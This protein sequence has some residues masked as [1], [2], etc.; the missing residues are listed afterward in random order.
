MLKVTNRLRKLGIKFELLDADRL[1]SEAKRYPEIIA[2]YLGPNWVPVLC[3][4]EMAASSRAGFGASEPSLRTVTG[5]FTEWSAFKNQDLDAIREEFRCGQTV[6]AR[7]RL[8]AFRQSSLWK[9][10][11]EEVKARALRLLASITLDLGGGVADARQLAEEARRLDA[12]ERVQILDALLAYHEGTAA[13][14]LA[15]LGQPRTVDAWNVQLALWLANGEKNRVTDGVATPSFP[16]NAETHRLYAMALLFSQRVEE[17]EAVIAESLAAQ[18]E[19]SAMRQS[20]ATIDYVA[21]INPHFH[22]WMHL[23][24]PVPS[25]RTLVKS[26][27][28]SRSKLVRSAAA[29]K[30]LL[31][32][33]PPDASRRA[34]LETW[35]LA[36]LANHPDT[37][38]EAERW[39][40]ELLNANAAHFRVVIWALE[41]GFK[42]DRPRVRAALGEL[43]K[44]PD[45][46]L[47]AVIALVHLISMDGDLA[48]ARAL[49]EAMRDRFVG[50]R[51]E[52]VWRFLMM[53]VLARLGDDPAADALLTEETD[54]D[55]GRK[56]RALVAMMRAQRS[57]AAPR[58]VSP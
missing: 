46:D 35:R 51:S 55:F 5:V 3:G 10:L 17:A 33:A 26:D 37:V 14:G 2:Q 13:D 22:A 45:A 28:A 21:T 43:V 44:S 41:R 20:Q 15:A 1:L 4:A 50:G 29:F 57:L 18:P 23:T 42:F 38:P 6:V 36:A 30:R 27:D 39:A 47:D 12:S 19:W 25:E 52:S 11:S 56:E 34:D 24:W 31:A 32:E 40:A 16:P 48:E 9:E 7:D 8:I 53:Q 58:Q 54:D 49:L